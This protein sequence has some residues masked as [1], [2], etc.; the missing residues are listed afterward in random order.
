M[1]TGME[2]ILSEEENKERKRRGNDLY[3]HGKNV[4]YFIIWCM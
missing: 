1:S 2:R 3:R 4:F